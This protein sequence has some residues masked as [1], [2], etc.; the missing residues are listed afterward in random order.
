MHTF[1][2]GISSQSDPQSFKNSSL[3]SGD[4]AVSSSHS[5]S[6]PAVIDSSTTPDSAISPGLSYGSS[7]QPVGLSP[8]ASITSLHNID[9]NAS[10]ENRDVVIH[11][12]DTMRKLANL[13]RVPSTKRRFSN[14]VLSPILKTLHR[15]SDVF[16]EYVLSYT[17]LRDVQGYATLR[18][19]KRQ[20]TESLEMEP[21][22]NTTVNSFVDENPRKARSLDFRTLGRLR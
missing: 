21:E 14:P 5:Y 22:K 11:P 17:S 6:K 1:P 13:K 2:T 4:R 10:L 7:T 3:S 16:N 8:I 18:E 19:L 12:S 15:D 20:R 9:E